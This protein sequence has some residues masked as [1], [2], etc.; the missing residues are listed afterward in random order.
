MLEFLLAFSE[1]NN[2]TFSKPL[3]KRRS[4]MFFQSHKTSLLL[5]LVVLLGFLFWGCA[6]TSYVKKRTKQIEDN[7]KTQMGQLE[8]KIS[9]VDAKAEEAKSRADEAWAKAEE[10]AKSQ[11]YAGYQ[12]IG[13]REVN[14]DFDR[15][16]L[17][18]IA[19][20]ILDE[21]GTMMQQRPELILEIAGYTDDVGPDAYNLILGDKRAETVRRY[22]AEKFDIAIFRMFRISFGESKP[23]TLND[24]IS[25]RAANRRA[26]LIILGPPE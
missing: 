25:G 3:T 2:Y 10:L 17:T 13:E 12:V 21:I 22:L 23:K 15:Y 8:K 5:S 16:D 20:D 6:T 26:T 4:G 14:F 24:T 19:T 9:S 11:G 7:T 1:K 18:K